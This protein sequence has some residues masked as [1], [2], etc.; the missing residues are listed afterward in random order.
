[1]TTHLNRR[2]LLKKSAAAAGA[3]VGTGAMAAPAILAEPSPNSKLGMAIIGANGRGMA[4][5]GAAMSQRLVALADVDDN[6][7]AGVMKAVAK[8][9]NADPSKIKTF[10]DFRKMFDEMHKQIDA[11]FV[12]TPENAHACASMMAIKLGKHVYCEKP[13]TH[14]IGEARALGEAARKYKVMTQMGNQGHAGE[15]I[16]VLRE[17]LEAGAIGTVLETHTWQDQVYGPRTRGVNR[18]VPQGLHWDEWIG[19]GAFC[20][21]R[22]GLHPSPGWYQW[23]DYGT[24]LLA[25]VGAHTFDAVFWG[26]QLKHPS[27]CV[28]LEQEGRTPDVWPTLNTLLYEFPRPG[29]PTLKSYW[30][31]GVRTKVDPL[32]KDKRNHPRL[33]DELTKQY[34]RDLTNGGTLF[35]GEKGIMFCDVYCGGPR[36]VPE[37]KHKEYPAPAKK[38]PRTR[39]I[40]ADFL[41]ACVE[42]GDPPCSNFPDVSG[43]YIEALLVGNLAMR[44]GVEK[45]V[46]WD[47]VAMKCT[48]LPEL[49]QYVKREYRAGWTL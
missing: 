39:G 19:P 7:M 2:E 45:K 29:L 32:V 33:A 3:V 21:Y 18:P 43:P 37:Q 49:N 17:Y 48:N 9:P 5:L 6:R 36:I 47:G 8:S 22:D 30:Y 10:F 16:R 1:M 11:V 28:A 31:D 23:M 27:S 20:D 26:L 4:H 12:A 13:L 25:C 35:V 42:G 34:G 41:R 46:E 40:Q 14:D 44:A 15:G 24:G 38:Y